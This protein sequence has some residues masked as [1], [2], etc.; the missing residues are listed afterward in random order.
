MISQVTYNKI[1][2]YLNI[3]QAFKK[4]LPGEVSVISMVGVE[5]V[6][7]LRNKKPKPNLLRNSS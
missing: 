7:A 5:A 4:T 6:A 1:E 3:K 2:T